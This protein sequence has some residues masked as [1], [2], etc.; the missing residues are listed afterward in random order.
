MGA[1]GDRVKACC[2]AHGPCE[3]EQFTDKIQL[4]PI[5]H[6]T[7][8]RESS[9]SSSEKNKEIIASYIRP[10]LK[11]PA[12]L[13]MTLLKSQ[14]SVEEVKR[15]PML[16]IKLVSSPAAKG[17][18]LEI[19]AQG[20]QGSARNAKDGVTYFG[21]EKALRSSSERLG[22]VPGAV[23]TAINDFVIPIKEAEMAERHFGRHFQISFDRDK[24]KYYI[25]DLGKGFGVFVRIDYPQVSVFCLA[26]LIKL[27]IGNQ[28]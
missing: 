24:K 7:A 3:A 20:L 9:A 10:P 22:S 12:D 19:N 2:C 15:A 23:A 17:A 16:R 8:V 1:A 14:I 28:R 25:R 6:E 4:A 21:C 11:I 27:P 13:P 18:E 26:R 5:S